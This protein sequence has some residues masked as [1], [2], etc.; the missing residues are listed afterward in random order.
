M[1]Y[2]MYIPCVKILLIRRNKDCMINF[3][4]LICPLLERYVI[5]ERP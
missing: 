3:D 2:C 4:D 1:I 5:V